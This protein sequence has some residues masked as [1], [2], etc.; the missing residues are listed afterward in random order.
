MIMRRQLIVATLLVAA[1]S[2]AHAADHCGVAYLDFMER[3]SH[4]AWTISPELLAKLHRTAL[5]IY[6]ACDTGVCKP[7]KPDSDNWNRV[8]SPFR[9]LQPARPVA[10]L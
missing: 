9:I 3:L 7:Q 2:A 5:R 4:R 1:A 10:V 8:N 6:Y